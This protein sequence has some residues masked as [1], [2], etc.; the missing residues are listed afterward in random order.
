MVP[1]PDLHYC[2]RYLEDA[3]DWLLVE[4]KYGK[5]Y[6]QDAEHIRNW[7]DV[8]T[9][10]DIFNFTPSFDI[11]ACVYREPTGHNFVEGKH[12]ACNFFTVTKY[13]QQEYVCYKIEEKNSYSIE[14]G[15][16]FRS[17]YSERL[18]YKIIFGNKFARARTI[19]PTLSVAS[20]PHIGRIYAKAY[21]KDAC[22]IT[23]N[24]ACHSIEHNFMGY[25]Y[26]RYHCSNYDSEYFDCFESCLNNATMK[27][28]S[29]KL[30]Y[31]YHF[32]P[33]DVKLIS[34]SML[35]NQTI[36][37]L[38]KVWHAQCSKTCSMFP[39]KFEFCIT[40]AHIDA[41][42]DH[43]KNGSI[44]RVESAPCPNMVTSNVPN[45]S[46]LD[47][48]IYTLSSLG[49]WF[50]LVIISCNPLQYVTQA[51]YA[52]HMRIENCI[53]R[54]E[55]NRRQVRRDMILRRMRM[56]SEFYRRHAMAHAHT[57]RRRSQSNL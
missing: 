25:P 13:V 11:D 44:V 37:M 33:H 29:R 46:L 8:L 47:F 9:I 54:L 49:T 30:S 51:K 7:L 45:V 40:D 5:I 23:I 16:I 43:G 20:L 27:Y 38:L 35:R 21:K 10:R 50:G 22:D 56:Q 17:L 18:L 32:Q 34:Q 41:K 52:V 1:F 36:V 14:F 3:I 55:R 15:H 53:K 4:G 26:D 19:R 42:V 24:L 39:C 2:F 31:F 6:T 48:V 28:L 57:S 12:E